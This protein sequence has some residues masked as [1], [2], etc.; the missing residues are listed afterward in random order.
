M[1][2]SGD[3]RGKVAVV[4]GG[5]RGIGAATAAALAAAGARVYVLDL[6]ADMAAETAQQIGS[7]IAL[8]ADIS[9]SAQVDAAFEQV[10]VERGRLDVLANVA[11]L[12]ASMAHW[13]LITSANNAR[14]AE[15]VAGGPVRTPIDATV[16]MSD[17]EWNSRIA[18][19]LTGTFFCC[20][21]ALRI[22]VPQRSGVIVNTAS[23]SAI[24]G[25]P[26]LAHYSAAKAG[27]IAMTKSLAREVID[28]GIRVNAVAPGSVRTPMAAEK[29][30]G[31]NPGAVAP[32]PAGRPGESEEIAQAILYLASDAAAY[33]VG[34]T[35]NINGGVVMD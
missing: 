33:V 2:F 20:R 24:S 3:F 13:D 32:I 23:N 5:A 8:A 28:Q 19:N 15:R 7:G 21:A 34:A 12:S 25:W 27:I 31:F 30:T 35:L 29:P 11:G 22:M 10:R 9:D 14:D 6:R 26:G 4:T 18:V 1:D 17:D 16:R